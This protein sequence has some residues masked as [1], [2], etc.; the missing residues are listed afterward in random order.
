MKFPRLT[1]V[2]AVFGASGM[3]AGLTQQWE[4][5]AITVRPSFASGRS[6]AG[7]SRLIRDGKVLFETKFNKLDGAGRPEATGDS[8]PTTRLRENDL[9]FTRIA[10]LDALSCAACH[11]QP[12]VGGSGDF[13]ANVFVG[14][15]FS[16]PP[17]KSI[18][19]EKTSER[20]STGLFGAGAIEVL[21][22]E[23]TEDLLAIKSRAVKQA[24]AK[25]APVRAL[26]KTKS[27]TFGY[28]MG[29][30]DGT[31]KAT[32]IRGVDSDLV[33]KPFGVK[34]VVI[35]LREFTINA[36][37][38]HHGIQSDERFGWE[39]TGVKDFD[40]DGR[41][42][43]FSL[44]QVTAVSLFQAALP[45]P[46]ASTPRNSAD[47]R[48]RLLG[49]GLF[50]KIGCASCHV[51]ALPLRSAVF[52]EPNR[53]NR[54]GNALPDDVSTPIRMPLPMT[55]RGTSGVYRDNM[56]VTRVAAYTDLRRHVIA[57]EGD[58]FFNNEKLRQ[59]NVPTDQFL[60]TKLWDLATSAPYG[61]RGD[62]TLISEAIL[63]H[64]GEARASRAAFEALP[65]AQKGQLISFLVS[66]GGDLDSYRI[67][68]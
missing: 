5:R 68:K 61:H 34:G 44:G 38:H 49:A 9:G 2:F 13:V 24:R 6:P 12:A 21:A 19:F 43:E 67:P 37:N 62:C 16:D 4:S 3:L 23:M 7:V 64:A 46:K 15:H 53:F 39:R 55:G 57:D 41:T 22:R 59:D 25:G 45:A 26:L 1:I 54:P 32:E 66:L 42:N 31:Y 56:G 63:H 35:S 11:N 60:T 40:G 48:E 29:M 50:Q 14:A 47:K 65:N 20:N 30:P 17:T 36:L 52:Q 58:P 51:P 18:E 27:V 10:G 28:V 8:K 33:V